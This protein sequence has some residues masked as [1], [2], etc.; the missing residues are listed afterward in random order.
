MSGHYDWLGRPASPRQLRNKELLEKIE[1]I[2]TE[3]RGTYGWPRVH[4]EPAR[5]SAPH[6]IGNRRRTPKRVSAA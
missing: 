6:R 1:A 2:H 5:I 4:A 3:T